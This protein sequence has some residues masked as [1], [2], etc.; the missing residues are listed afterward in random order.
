[1]SKLTQEERR[2]LDTLELHASRME[3]I[4][5][6]LEILNDWN[7]FHDNGLKEDVRQERRMRAMLM[8]EGMGHLTAYYHDEAMTV[9][10]RYY[11]MQE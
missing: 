1:M 9:V 6:M 8:L 7:P 3:S 10:K 5:A 11:N 2:L 4:R